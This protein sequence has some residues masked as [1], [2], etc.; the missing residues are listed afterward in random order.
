MLVE[1]NRVL[2][3]ELYSFLYLFLFLSVYLSTY[4]FGTVFLSLSL[5]HFFSMDS[6]LVS[7]LAVACSLSLFLYIS[8]RNPAVSSG[9]HFF[10]R[11]FAR[12]SSDGCLPTWLQTK[13]RVTLFPM[14]FRPWET[15]VAILPRRWWS[16]KSYSSL[17]NSSLC[18]HIMSTIYNTITLSL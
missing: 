11:S 1:F 4:T 9:A 13:C 18:R 6:F 7:S 10:A 15:L 17:Y 16:K 12:E 8:S 2:Q 5:F 14:N 3:D